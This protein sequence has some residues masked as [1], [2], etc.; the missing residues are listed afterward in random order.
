MTAKIEPLIQDEFTGAPPTKRSLAYLLKKREQGKKIAGIYCGYAPVEIIRAMGAVP[1]TL[2]AF[3]NGTIEK[4]ETVLPANL[5]PLIKSSYGFIISDTCPFYAISD[6]VIGETTCDGKKKMFELIRDRKPTH[7]MDLPQ[8][9]DEK[10]AVSNWTVTIRKLQRF[11]E[12]AL[13]AEASDEAI[14]KELRDTNKKNAMMRRVFDFMAL[15][16]SVVGWQEIHDL[17]FLAQSA[18]SREMEPVVQ[19]AVERLEARRKAGYGHGK[20][21]SPRVLVTGCPVSGDAQKVFTVIE[22]AGGVIVTL[23]SCTG[24]KPYM[25]DIEEGKDDPG[26]A[27]AERYLKIPCSCM[28]PNEGRLAAMSRLI[29]KFKPD[30]V[31]DIVLQA[32]HSYNIESYKVGEYVRNKHGLPFL[33]VVTDFSQSDVG[34]LRT[35]I[36][37]LLGV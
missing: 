29:E 23:D 25:D 16:P 15:T 26:I 27:L 7:I 33:K 21:D 19:T 13:K 2:C 8:L 31:V 32:C 5:C 22:E 11:L 28:T 3:S 18:T 10:E 24:F 36:E 37:A 17:T 12:A 1:A 4:A 9:P 30:A 20:Q 14:E 34:Q 6:V 35:R